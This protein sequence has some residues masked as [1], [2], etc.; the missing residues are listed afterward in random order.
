MIAHLV[1][2]KNKLL[3]F[4]RDQVRSYCA[5]R[6]LSP[7]PV[8]YGIIPENAKAVFRP[9]PE[10][11]LWEG[12]SDWLETLSERK[13]VLNVYRSIAHEMQHYL[14][15]LNYMK[16]YGK[17]DSGAFSEKEAYLEGDDLSE[18]L[19]SKLSD[20]I[21]N[22]LVDSS[23]YESFHGSKPARKRM[24]NYENPTGPL[25]KIGRI[26]RIDYEPEFPSKHRG[27]QFYHMAGDTGSRKLP[28]NMILA[29]DSKGENFYLIKDKPGKYPN[30]SERGIIG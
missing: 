11:I 14:Q 8:R 24:V 21:I 27:T 15:Y 13:R 7:I 4:V 19:V 25:I 28:S 9:T 6:N 23:L 20:E 22:P 10:I 5:K 26:R 12:Y 17:V 16:K 3:R 1:I 29:C 18:K 2:N 30:F